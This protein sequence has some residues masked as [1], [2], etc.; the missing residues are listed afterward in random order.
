MRLSDLGVR[1]G[2]GLVL[3]LVLIS[4]GSALAQGTST[5]NGRALDQGDAVLPGVTV[6]VTNTSTGVVR[7]SVTNAEGAF[8][9]PGLEPGIYNIKSELPGFQTSVR[10]RVNL[11]V[12]TTITLDFKLALASVTEAVTV[13]GEAPLIEV[14]QSKVA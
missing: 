13:T 7:T 3:S 6:T 8:Y 4:T 11:A 2:L 1:H 14:S 12:N 10:D 5:F 9:I